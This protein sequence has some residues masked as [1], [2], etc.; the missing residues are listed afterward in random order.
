MA[1]EY[2]VGWGRKVRQGRM[3]LAVFRH[4]S[5][6]ASFSAKTCSQLVRSGLAFTSSEAKEEEELLG[7]ERHP[8]QAFLMPN[9]MDNR[10]LGVDYSKLLSQPDTLG[11]Q[12]S[13]LLTWYQQQLLAIS[14]EDSPP[15]LHQPTFFVLHWIC[16]L[17]P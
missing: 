13:Q 2:T 9:F 17:I 15:I 16:Q 7:C 8:H 10:S 1:V 3:W 11:D 12:R 5:F 4:E 6:P 14:A